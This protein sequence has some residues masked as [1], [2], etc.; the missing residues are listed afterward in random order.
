MNDEGTL[1]M[2]GQ[3]EAVEVGLPVGSGERLD[4]V[5]QHPAELSGRLARQLAGQVVDGHDHGA[6]TVEAHPDGF[7][8]GV[9]CV[10]GRVGIGR[11]DGELD[12]ALDVAADVGDRLQAWLTTLTVVRLRPLAR[13]QPWVALVPVGRIDQHVEVWQVAI[14]DTAVALGVVVV[15]LQVE[16]TVERL[17][18]VLFPEDDHQQRC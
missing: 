11:L 16:R 3:L 13:H 10:A 4:H 14:E 7:G 2:R 6:G 9:P 15:L 1:Q 17:D 5:P 8:L 18:H 12:A